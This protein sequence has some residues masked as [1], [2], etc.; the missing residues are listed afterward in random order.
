MVEEIKL[1]YYWR[2][3]WQIQGPVQVGD[4]NLSEGQI[5]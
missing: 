4:V 3:M 1:Q 2:E 5:L